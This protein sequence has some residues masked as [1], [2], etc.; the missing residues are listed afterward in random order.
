[1]EIDYN[2][3]DLRNRTVFD[4]TDDPNIL[5]AIDID[6]SEKDDYI[7]TS[8]PIAKAFGIYDYAEYIGDQLLMEAVDKEFEKEF[9][10]FFNE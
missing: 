3:L 6:I 4:F 9:S 8:L 5:K 1:M 2:N 10:E 7:R